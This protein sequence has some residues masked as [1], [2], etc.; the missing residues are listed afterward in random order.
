[1]TAAEANPE[2]SEADGR[3]FREKPSRFDSVIEVLGEKLNPIL[4]KEARQAMK[5]KQFLITFM[6]LLVCGWGW[7]ILG[8]ALQAGAVYYAE[9]GQFMLGGYFVVLTVPLMI[10][11]PFASFRSI[12]AEKDHGTFELLSITALNSRQI[13]T[14]KLAVSV[15]Q[16]VVYMS[17]L[18][19]F[20]A[21][22]YLL[23]GV[24]LLSIVWVLSHTGLLSLAFCSVGILVGTLTRSSHWQ[25][26]LSVFLLAAFGFG[27][28]GWMAFV[29]NVLLDSQMPFHEPQFW[30][31]NAYMV[32][33]LITYIFVAI[34]AASSMVSFASDNRSTPIRV[35]LLIQQAIWLGFNFYAWREF[36]DNDFLTILVIM[37]AIS[38]AIA[39]A[40]MTGEMGELSTRV[41]RSLPRTALGRI[42]LTWFFPGS[43]TGYVFAVCNYGVIMIAAMIMAIVADWANLAGAPSRREDPVLLS[44]MLFCFLVGYLGVGRLIILAV[45]TRYPLGLFPSLLVHVVLAALG[46]VVPT[47]FQL[48]LHRVFGSD[49]GPIQAV[50]W[51]WTMNAIM[52]N[53]FWQGGGIFGFS[54][55]VIIAPTLAL[56]VFIAN[57]LFAVKEVEQV[58]AASPQRVLDDQRKA[59]PDAKTKSPWDDVDIA[60]DDDAVNNEQISRGDDEL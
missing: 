2:I 36:G 46:A 60:E 44:F 51:A 1:M 32:T 38:W 37:P 59:V 57:L 14:G 9:S 15:L 6:L 45:R 54:A 30:M 4:V 43:G 28:F 49:Y 12:A 8:I 27:A 3:S 19:P 53:D 35:T 33:M 42:V 55:N 25:V 21:F 24:D 52:E 48:M 41:K 56:I 13:V 58:R 50:N 10:I 29:F 16:I 5:S 34:V 23:R 18:A 31:G 22:T 7:S 17:A 20:I 11:V 26:V 39:G 40:L 47:V